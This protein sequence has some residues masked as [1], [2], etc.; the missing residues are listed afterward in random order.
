[1]ISVS[2]DILD[3]LQ[4]YYGPE[5]DIHLNL[6]EILNFYIHI[7]N[8]DINNSTV[9]YGKE[10]YLNV[11]RMQ[12]FTRY[13]KNETF[14]AIV[15]ELITIIEDST[16]EN[17]LFP[18]ILFI[19]SFMP[20]HYWHQKLFELI[21]NKFY[22]HQYI[23][24]RCVYME[25]L[26][27]IIDT[28]IIKD[29]NIS[30][31][32]S[33]PKDTLQES[34]PMY[35]YIEDI[36]S[37]LQEVLF[38]DSQKHPNNIWN[39]NEEDK[40]IELY[41][42]YIS[43]ICELIYIQSPDDPYYGY[44]RFIEFINFMIPM[45]LKK[46]DEKN[47]QLIYILFTL[48]NYLVQ[49]E[50]LNTENFINNHLSKEQHN[51]IV[52]LFIDTWMTMFY[53]QPELP[54]LA[55]TS[56]SGLTSLDPLYICNQFFSIYNTVMN[57]EKKDDKIIIGLLTL[58]GDICSYL[59]PVISLRTQLYPFTLSLINYI[60]I[61]NLEISAS[62]LTI[63][64]NIFTLC[65]ELPDRTCIFVSLDERKEWIMSCVKQI[66][67]FYIRGMTSNILKLSI[68]CQRLITFL[69]K[70]DINIIS[71]SIFDDIDT[72]SEI[73][74]V[75][76]FKVSEVFFK[77]IYSV[78]PEVY[79]HYIKEK[80]EAVD[81]LFKDIN[82]L[83]I[84]SN[85]IHKLIKK[86]TNNINTM[87]TAVFFF[88]QIDLPDSLIDSLLHIFLCIL[89]SGYEDYTF[90]IFTYIDKFIYKLIPEIQ[91]NNYN[92]EY[93][94]EMT[95][96]STTDD[97]EKEE[98]IHKAATYTFNPTNHN[99]TYDSISESTIYT[100]K[101]MIQLFY[102]DIYTSILSDIN[103]NSTN[104]MD[105]KQKTNIMSSI[106]FILPI[107]FPVNSIYN[108]YISKE[109]NQLRDIFFNEK[110]PIEVCSII[111][112][113]IQGKTINAQMTESIGFILKPYLQENK[114]E[115]TMQSTTKYTNLE[116]MKNIYLAYHKHRKETAVFGGKYEYIVY[117]YNKIIDIESFMNALN[118]NCSINE[119]I[120][121]Y[122]FSSIMN[123]IL[124]LPITTELGS[125]IPTLETINILISLCYKSGCVPFYII[126]NMFCDVLKEINSQNMSSINLTTLYT[127]TPA[128]LQFMANPFEN[129]KKHSIFSFITGDKE[130]INESIQQ[131]QQYIINN[132]EVLFSSSTVNDSN[133]I[134]FYNYMSS[135]WEKVPT[136]TQ[137]LF[138]IHLFGYLLN[139]SSVSIPDSL[140]N[141]LCSL[142]FS[143]INKKHQVA[144]SL[145]IILLLVIH[146][147]RNNFFITYIEF[148]EQ[149]QCIQ[150]FFNS[151]YQSF[152]LDDSS[153]TPDLIS[154]SGIKILP[155]CTVLHPFYMMDENIMPRM[156]QMNY[157]A[158]LFD[159]MKTHNDLLLPYIIN[160]IC[161]K[162]I[163]CDDDHT[164]IYF[165]VYVL[166]YSCITSIMSLP[167][168]SPFYENT[169]EMSLSLNV[170]SEIN[171]EAFITIFT[172]LANID[173]IVCYIKYILD[174]MI[175]ITNPI[176][177]TVL[178]CTMN[179]I[180][181]S[182]SWKLKEIQKNSI[183]S[184]EGHT[185][186]V[187]SFSDI[188]IKLNEIYTLFFNTLDT[189][190]I[191]IFPPLVRVVTECCLHIY[192][193]TK[194]NK[195]FEERINQYME[196][197]FNVFRDNIKNPPENKPICIAEF[198]NALID[199]Y[200]HDDERIR[201]WYFEM[202]KI[203]VETSFSKR[204]DVFENIQ[205]TQEFKYINKNVKQYF[206]FIL[207]NITNS[208]ID[209]NSCS[210]LLASITHFSIGNFTRETTQNKLF[211]LDKLEILFFSPFENIRI[212]AKS[213]FNYLYSFM[214]NENLTTLV[215]HFSDIYNRKHLTDEQK[216]MKP[217]V[218]KE[219][220]IYGLCSILENEYICRPCA[221]DA[222]KVILNHIPLSE[223]CQKIVDVSFQELLKQ[224]INYYIPLKTYFTDEEWDIIASSNNKLNYFS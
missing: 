172:F 90:Y 36:Y 50:I 16:T 162:M 137:K 97:K 194:G 6:K 58:F 70:T 174:K 40:S 117:I 87:F 123:N 56:I 7:N 210:L 133:I 9:S 18:A 20:D 91:L 167:S 94:K 61:N 143:L 75:D 45:S 84:S 11:N 205:E 112:D 42:G 53:N 214:S 21:L 39:I 73:K 145:S 57:Q 10:Q 109:I 121:Q 44:N 129:I 189:I 118:R 128:L 116:Q 114:F 76:D 154:L 183:L 108:K 206:D 82:P 17:K 175:K 28:Y 15:P 8:Y 138:Y 99:F 200:I 83:V 51:V 221:I 86:Y 59:F 187:Q 24:I 212:Q 222:I 89:S 119:K 202:F 55:Y 1:M 188:Q 140:I 153:L 170:S 186:E 192:I 47:I 209:E 130:K 96:Y 136:L 52:H 49:H 213:F 171:C 180:V 95:L 135:L 62:V 2:F 64:Y 197:S 158:L 160:E 54:D 107:I 80:I 182:Y 26:S 71:K 155:E 85:Q 196:K 48:Y 110:H 65:P 176:S 211:Y 178:I 198:S 32:S 139:V 93:P 66:C 199:F 177:I 106:S 157:I 124:H 163:L 105:W 29:P 208:E 115:V 142:L 98:A 147:K 81:I 12:H 100:I 165:Y 181:R 215:K 126:Q 30:P 60:D 218:L 207:S 201:Q 141:P 122:N 220:A 102:V 216:L 77:Y 127:V 161:K 203:C 134:E 38:E 168:S 72:I 104:I 68:L 37:C 31:L 219:G 5:L 223:Q 33:L 46:G 148:L 41:S 144:S 184:I 190:D 67:R 151:L 92:Y 88:H 69:T 125:P 159:A 166:Y 3:S 78:Y 111:I 224:S 43:S 164:K 25:V 22:N 191:F 152:I 120:T 101:R 217:E 195:K 193:N 169:Q 132:I 14:D 13:I 34:F 23:F 74:T 150:L 173:E 156:P 4:V 35:M 204:N 103:N 185:H 19:A 131:T 179:Y 63:I 113:Y 27:D 149:N 79:I 146:S